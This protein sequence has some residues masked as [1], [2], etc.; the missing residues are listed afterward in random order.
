M[1]KLEMLKIKNKTG[2]KA[3]ISFHLGNKLELKLLK[4]DRKDLLYEVIIKDKTQIENLIEKLKS[5]K[6]EYVVMKNLKVIFKAKMDRIDII[7][8]FTAFNIRCFDLQSGCNNYIEAPIINE[9]VILNMI[10]NHKKNLQLDKNKKTIA[11]MSL[12]DI[13]ENENATFYIAKQSENIIKRYAKENDLQIYETYID[14][15]PSR[16]NVKNRIALKCLLDKIKQEEI[17]QV[18]IPKIEHI[19]RN[20]IMANSL[21]NEICE[22]GTKVVCCNEN[23]ILG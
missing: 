16:L 1:K 5:K 17:G 19:S 12:K 13:K 9:D 4:K 14:H 3:I 23:L 20:T 18:L 15:I 8:K 21:I 7:N 10:T 6:I 22:A 11:Y 2:K